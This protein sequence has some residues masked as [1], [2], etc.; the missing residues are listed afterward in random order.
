MFLNLS[1]RFGSGTTTQAG[2]PS[3]KYLR[4]FS[5]RAS[6]FINT[7]VKRSG[8]INAGE[9][10][11]MSEVMSGKEEENKHLRAQISLESSFRPTK[12]VSQEKAVSLEFQLQA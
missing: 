1:R 4:R 5:A 8:E 10:I 9:S 7:K 11:Q 6:W 3:K 2:D 12:R